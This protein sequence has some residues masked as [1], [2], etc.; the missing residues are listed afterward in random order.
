MKAKKAKEQLLAIALLSSVFVFFIYLKTNPEI[1]AASPIINVSSNHQDQINEIINDKVQ[2]INYEITEPVNE[3]ILTEGIN[4]PSQIKESIILFTER[5][6]KR[7]KAYIDKDWRPDGTINMAA[8]DYVSKN[9]SINNYKN[10]NTSY[11][12]SNQVANTNIK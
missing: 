11:L 5:E 6:L 9:P 4:K 8:W 7:A 12:E 10:E 2:E 3:K 1:N